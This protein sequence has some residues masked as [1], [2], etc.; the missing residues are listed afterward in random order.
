MRKALD[1][2]G[3]PVV[4]L[5]TGEEIG[6]IRDILFDSDNWQV[7]GVLL[8][9]QGWLQSGTYIPLGRIHAVGESCLTVSG[10]DAIT[11]LDQLAASEPTGVL[12]GKL[13]LKGKSVISASGNLLGRLEDVYFSADWEKI[14]GYEL[15]NGW[16]ADVT[17]GRKRLSVP[18]SVIIGEENLIVPD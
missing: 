10:K 8:S 5:D 14:V 4:C 15:S 6:V 9:E 7:A 1:V 11:S 12:T 17:E 16:L 13:K 3:M 2:V 18:P